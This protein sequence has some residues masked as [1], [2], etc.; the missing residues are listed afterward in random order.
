MPIPQTPIGTVAPQGIG[1][2]PDE[3][4]VSP[5]TEGAAVAE[6]VERVGQDVGQVA[7]QVEQQRAH[8]DRA[9]VAGRVGEVQNEVN[10]SILNPLTGYEATSGHGA[11]AGRDA[12]LAKVAQR[13]VLA[14]SKLNGDNQKTMF[15]EQVR[16]IQQAAILH[17]AHHEAQE[18]EV[19]FKAENDSANEAHTKAGELQA[20]LGNL[21]G[22]KS[23]LGYVRQNIKARADYLGLIP[24]A[25]PGAADAGE[26][27]QSAGAQAPTPATSAYA[28]MNGKASAAYAARVMKAV[29]DSVKADST[30]S[31]GVD[32]AGRV[33]DFLAPHLEGGVASWAADRIAALR[34]DHQTEK[35]ADTILA[36]SLVEVLLPDGTKTYRVDGAKKRQVLES[37][38]NG[39]SPEVDAAQAALNAAK[40]AQTQTGPSAEMPHRDEGQL[41]PP[42]SPN[43]SPLIAGVPTMTT[44]GENPTAE[45]NAD[46]AEKA[47]ALADARAAA[48]AKYAAIAPDVLHALEKREL[49]THKAWEQ[50]VAEVYGK[51]VDAGRDPATGRFDYQ[52]AVAD[53]RGVWLNEHQ[54]DKDLVGQL[55]AKD[56]ADTRQ[57]EHSLRFN[58]SQTRWA[59]RQSDR[60]EKLNRQRIKEVSSTN[61]TEIFAQLGEPESRAAFL[62]KTKEILEQDLGRVFTDRDGVV[63][64]SYSEEDKRKIVRAWER[65]RD[66]KQ[67]LEQSP[68]SI[69]SQLVATGPF[70]KA[71]ADVQR[72]VRAKLA[73]D[74]HGR[75]DEL[76]RAGDKNPASYMARTLSDWAEQKFVKEKDPTSWFGRTRTRV[77]IE[78]DQ[79][80]TP[81]AAPA[82]DLAASMVQ[83]AAPALPAAKQPTATPAGMIEMIS[84]EGAR[85]HIPIANEAA[86][87]ARGLKRAR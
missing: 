6:G 32:N 18:T 56:L 38:R 60:R 61:T 86:A 10:D 78:L 79:G 50:T 77:E 5:D 40:S 12:A 19:V 4:R 63:R 73:Q 3:S 48:A 20:V 27:E 55:H 29:L 35:T 24:E 36:H 53:G 1:Y 46:L 82:S 31:A 47:K 68:E 42:G 22:V 16:P 28:A 39:K 52:R 30:N 14:K 62:G 11:M 13:I 2:H 72:R 66:T 8:A 84:P 74:I 71:S 41:V 75:L 54:G 51:A 7:Q 57:D 37:L 49:D 80:R 69:A 70:Q 81:V 64:P 76:E 45:Q 44:V 58:E 33:Y 85:F 21:D 83:P 17:A 65:G 26:T 25:K 67:K 9:N 15:D 23:A 43:T 34:K 59:W 87:T